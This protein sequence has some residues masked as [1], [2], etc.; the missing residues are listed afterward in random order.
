M[1]GL[2][3]NT[4]FNRP[5]NML[6]L[7]GYPTM[8]FCFVL[9]VMHKEMDFWPRVY[10]S[11]HLLNVQSKFIPRN[12]FISLQVSVLIFTLFM[13]SFSLSQEIFLFLYRSLEF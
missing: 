1:F 11:L 8:A 13:Y 9:D 3:K 4:G 5:Q 10:S 12:Y 2:E 7:H 6:C